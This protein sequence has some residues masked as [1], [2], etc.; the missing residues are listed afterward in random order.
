MSYEWINKK[1]GGLGIKASVNWGDQRINWGLRTKAS[2]N[3]LDQQVN[4]KFKYQDINTLIRPIYKPK[5]EEIMI[6]SWRAQGPLWEHN[7]P[8]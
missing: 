3:W 4:R 1:T 6:I 7:A 2:S 5:V 8:W